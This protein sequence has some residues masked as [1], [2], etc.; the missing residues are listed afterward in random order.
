GG[1]IGARL[2]FV[3]EHWNDQFKDNL[4]DIFAINEGGISIY[5]ALIGGMI[6][7]FTYV[8][9]RRHH[10]PALPMADAAAPGTMLGMAIGRIGDVINGEHI[11][12]AS[13]LP[14]AVRYTHP[15]SLSYGL[16]PQHP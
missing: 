10:V 14:W 12:K 7:G 1:I 5:G 2:L 15:G 6:F 11:S 16:P 8:F 3:I 13:D 9:L 4:S